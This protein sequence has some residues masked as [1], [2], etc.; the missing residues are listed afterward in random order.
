MTATETEV[1]CPKC[2]GG[3]YDNRLTKKNPKQPDF[4]CKRYKE[5]CEGV[6]WPPK[7]FGGRRP[8]VVAKP[9][10]PS[11]SNRSNDELPDYLRDAEQEDVRELQAKIGFDTAPLQK[12]LSLYQALTEYV[13]R[14]IAPIYEKAKIGL[15]PESTAAITA[16]LY[17]S[18]K[19][20]Q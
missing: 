9:A 1:A 11:F 5:G 18:A 20:T 16:T 15:S 7:E 13:I 4:K 3:M 6:V 12:D 2:G 17:I 14:D 10:P 19:K 8:A